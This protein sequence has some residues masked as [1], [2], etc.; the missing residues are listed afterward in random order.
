MDD[1]KWM[2]QSVKIDLRLHYSFF[3]FTKRLGDI[4]ILIFSIKQ[5]MVG[6]REK[7]TLPQ[8]EVFYR[9]SC[10]YK[11]EWLSKKETILVE[12]KSKKN[13]RFENWNPWSVRVGLHFL[14]PKPRV[15][16]STLTVLHTYHVFFQSY[17]RS[18]FSAFSGAAKASF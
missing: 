11:N 14:Y 18:I 10:S 12:L 13:D 7:K 8:R 3:R 6:T 9:P 16:E 17:G 15:I 4:F 1:P 2:I 5:S